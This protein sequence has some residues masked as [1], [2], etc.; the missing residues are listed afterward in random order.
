MGG[1]RRG[2]S[3]HVIPQTHLGN[4]QILPNTP[5]MDLQTGKTNPTTQ[6]RAAFW[7]KSERLTSSQGKGVP[8]ATG[9]ESQRGRGP[10]FPKFLQPEG[11]QAW[12]R[13]GQWARLRE[14]PHS[15]WTSESTWGPRDG[16]GGRVLSSAGSP[17]RP[18]RSKGPAGALYLPRP[19]RKQRS[20]SGTSA[21][22]A[23]FLTHTKLPA[24]R[25]P[26]SRHSRPPPP[27][28]SPKPYAHR[29]P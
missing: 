18:S 22:N 1:E 6:G 20:S 3:A 28:T 26:Q 4:Y 12:N 7:E 13:K 21:D 29:V 25:W 16:G 17:E 15:L 24:L 19:Q 14:H 27:K 9:L 5:E 11:L 2:S 8:R 23:P 10:E